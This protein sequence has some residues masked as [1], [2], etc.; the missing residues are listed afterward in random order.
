MSQWV[1]V[2][3]KPL[4]DATM[5]EIRAGLE[6]MGLKLNTGVSNINN[7]YGRSECVARIERNGSSIDLGINQ[8]DGEYVIVG[9]FYFSGYSQNEFVDSISKYTQKNK[10]MNS[11]RNNQWIADNVVENKDGTIEIYATK[12]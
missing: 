6:D 7:S 5:E 4:K 2:E 1:K 11:L 10:I 8:V 12:Y 9:D 3:A